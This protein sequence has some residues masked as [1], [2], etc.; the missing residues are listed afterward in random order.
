MKHVWSWLSLADASSDRLG[1]LE[2]TER[3]RRFAKLLLTLFEGQAGLQ[4]AATARVLPLGALLATA[5]AGCPG[6][7]R[8]EADAAFGGPPS[9]ADCGAAFVCVCK[10][11]AGGL[12]FCG[13][14]TAVH[15]FYFNLFYATLARYI[16]SPLQPCC[17]GILHSQ[18]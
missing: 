11:A 10:C 18:P 17:P 12:Y 5:A 3:R 8:T 4:R 13:P 15:L 9:P 14:M 1:A 7:A 6:V 2:L 16:T